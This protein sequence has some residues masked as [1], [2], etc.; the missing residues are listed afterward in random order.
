MQ[1]TGHTLV[2]RERISSR[3]RAARAH[4]RGT[5]NRTASLL[6]AT[7]NATCR[8]APKLAGKFGYALFCSPL[9]RRKV[10]ADEREWHDRAAVGS[11]VVNG[12]RA[13]TY[14]WGDGRKPVLMLHG[15]QSRSSCYASF[16]PKLQAL[17]LTPIGFDAPGHGD[18][19]GRATTIVEYC[20]IAL[21]LQ[22]RYGPFEAILGHSLGVTAAF[23]ALRSGV[24]AGRLVVVSGPCDFDYLVDSFC[25]ELRLVDPLKQD[26][27]HRLET[28][29]FASEADM[30]T[31]FSALHRPSD[32]TLPILV[33]HDDSDARIHLE[34][35]HKLV[36]AYG[37]QAELVTTHQLGH[38]RIL[39]DPD[40]INRVTQFL[41]TASDLSEP[42]IKSEVS[43]L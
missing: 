31:R 32:I 35:A 41:R 10:R 7:L 25:R 18:S 37:V 34:Q 36:A 21:E 29:L 19:E 24:R 8:V 30:W 42:R 15:W 26:I 33:I 1:Q 39:R 20:E 23:L 14:C 27:R 16:I 3:S 11:V 6:G 38:H 28:R 43:I 5:M 2:S 40:V 13:S 12:K 4:T 22:R 17:G 9:P